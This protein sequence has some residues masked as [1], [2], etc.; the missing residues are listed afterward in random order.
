MSKKQVRRYLGGKKRGPKKG[1]HHTKD[2]KEKIS[3]GLKGRKLSKDHRE[4]ISKRMQG[5][6][7]PRFSPFSIKVELPNDGGVQEYEFYGKEGKGSPLQEALEELGLN[8]TKIYKLKNEGDWT[9]NMQCSTMRKNDWPIGTKVSYRRLK[10]KTFKEYY[11]ATTLNEYAKSDPMMHPNS[12]SAKKHSKSLMSMDRKH[13]NLI[14]KDYQ[15]KNAIVD[16]IFKSKGERVVSGQVL[17]NLL[18]D[19]NMD[20]KE[21]CIKGLGKG[22]KL[23]MYIDNRGNKVGILHHKDHTHKYEGR[24]K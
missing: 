16:S 23:Y 15:S 4:H 21:G 24:C 5:A 17:T 18:N 8:Q 11:E 6:N 10:M 3:K 9:I 7:N 13:L 1:Y 22:A 14:K 19:Y 12:T 20:F 2:A